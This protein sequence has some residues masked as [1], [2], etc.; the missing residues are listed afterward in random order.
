[1]GY[2]IPPSSGPTSPTD[3]GTPQDDLDRSPPPGVTGPACPVTGWEESRPRSLHPFLTSPP[4]VWHDGQR[5]FILGVD[6]V[7]WVTA[8]L[9]FD[10]THLAYIEVHRA[11]Y[12]WPREAVGA[13]LARA[14]GA[15]LPAMGTLLAELGRWSGSRHVPFG[16]SVA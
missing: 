12:H 5:V 6:P 16:P 10:Q 4:F 8:E 7:G 3:H 11:I 2:R 13:F 15:S 9:R 14:C 1:M